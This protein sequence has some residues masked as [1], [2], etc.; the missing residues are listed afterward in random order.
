LMLAVEA[1]V[2]TLCINVLQGSRQ[3]ENVEQ[4]ID[5]NAR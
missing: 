5:K 1:R 4:S 2:T 3:I